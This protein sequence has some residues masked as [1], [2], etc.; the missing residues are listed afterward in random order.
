LGS[1]AGTPITAPLRPGE[2]YT[3]TFVFDLPPDAKAATLLVNE[4]DW[5]TR[6]IIGHENSLWHKKTRF[7]L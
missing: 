4:S 3:T 7:Q 5:I 2:S 1:Q 6:L